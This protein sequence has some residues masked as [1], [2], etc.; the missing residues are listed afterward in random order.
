MS[1]CNCMNP[2]FRSVGSDKVFL[3]IDKTNGRFGEVSVGTC[4]ACGRAWL[5]YFVEYEAFSR[6]GRWYRGL[7]SPEILDSLKPSDA[8]EVLAQLPWYFYGGSFFDTTG[9]RG[10]GGVSVDL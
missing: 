9:R 3:G 8:P 1:E 6:S 2:T 7:V 4:K 5:Q 10:Q